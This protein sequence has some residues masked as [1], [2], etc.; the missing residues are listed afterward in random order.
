MD[1]RHRNVEEN[2]ASR[3]DKGLIS[4]RGPTHQSVPC[5]HIVR[6]NEVIFISVVNEKLDPMDSLRVTEEIHSLV[7]LVMRD[8]DAKE[9]VFQNATSSRQF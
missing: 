4:E 7:V 6:D 1:N 5:M 2:N 3:K 9:V 8:F